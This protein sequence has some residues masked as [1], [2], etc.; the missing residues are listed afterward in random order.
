MQVENEA[1]HGHWKLWL[2][3]IPNLG[4]TSDEI[5]LLPSGEA[6]WITECR[7]KEACRTR[8]HWR[9]NDAGQLLLI[10]RDGREVSRCDIEL[11]GDLMI[12]RPV[13]KHGYRS[14]FERVEEPTTPSHHHQPSF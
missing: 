14:L 5:T 13:P 3:E 4:C 2:T 9:I 11:S 8:V 1:C 6:H 7:Y 10:T 12:I